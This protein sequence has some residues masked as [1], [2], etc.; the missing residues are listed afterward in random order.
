MIQLEHEES[1][2]DRVKS[3]ICLH[4]YP[5][6]LFLLRLSATEYRFPKSRFIVAKFPSFVEN[7]LKRK[8]G[9]FDLGK[10]LV[11][12][13][14]NSDREFDFPFAHAPTILFQR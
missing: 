12:Q 6:I 8:I 11:A 13:L 7:E 4:L 14:S 1:A 5:R 2:R 9:E 10:L 3:A